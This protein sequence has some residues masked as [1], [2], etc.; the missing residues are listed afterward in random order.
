MLILEVGFCP[1]SVFGRW[2]GPKRTTT[3]TWALP[4]ACAW[5][6]AMRQGRSSCGM[7]SVAPPTVRSRSTPNPSKVRDALKSPFG[8]CCWTRLIGRPRRL[9]R[10]WIFLCTLKCCGPFV[11]IRSHLP[12]VFVLPL[13][14][15]V[16]LSCSVPHSPSVSA[17]FG[18][19]VESGCLA[20]P[21]AGRPPP[22]LHCL[23]EWRHGHE[24]VEEELCWEHPLLFLWPLRLLQHGV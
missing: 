1:Y 6:L 15:A 10:K 13:A 4:T 20:W 19:A 12:S 11:F 7:W 16:T 9:C 8:S 22:Q 24:A 18:V 3:T 23:V 21:A 2:N 17:R 14:P 5:R